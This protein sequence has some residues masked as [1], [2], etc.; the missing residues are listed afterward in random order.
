MSVFP[1]V[2]SKCTLATS[3]AA[4]WWVTVS[5]LMRQTDRWMPDRYNTLSARHG[6]HNNPTQQGGTKPYW[7]ATWRICNE[8]ECT[9]DDRRRCQTPK[10]KTILPPTS[11]V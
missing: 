7:P 9:Y 8:M 3:D 2:W 5:M 4:P 1:I 6:Q 10:S 11:C